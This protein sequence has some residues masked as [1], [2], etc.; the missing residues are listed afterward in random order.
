MQEPD[1][2][3]ELRDY[4]FSVKIQLHDKF[5]KNDFSDKDH[6]HTSVPENFLRIFFATAPAATLAMVSLAEDLPP[7]YIPS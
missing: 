3:V 4:S 2:F 6:K 1:H 5:K 7:P